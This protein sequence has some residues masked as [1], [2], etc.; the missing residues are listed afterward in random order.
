M[1]A[2]RRERA[3]EERQKDE[4]RDDDAETRTVAGHRFKRRGS[5]W[6]DV[7]YDSNRSTVNVS[8]GSEQYRVLVGDE[9]GLRTIADQLSG[10]VI[11]VWK[12]RAYRIR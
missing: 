11:V 1:S 4:A 7:L 9:P 12:N 3:A 5:V 6:T 10:T 2:A 8:R